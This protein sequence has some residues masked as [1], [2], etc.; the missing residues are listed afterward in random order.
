MTP[1]NSWALPASVLHFAAAYLV[2][3]TDL[4]PRPLCDTIP[5]HAHIA[6]DPAPRPPAPETFAAIGVLL[7]PIA[8]C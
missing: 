3:T 6:P 4:I 2:I 7:H 1:D 8:Q 5:R